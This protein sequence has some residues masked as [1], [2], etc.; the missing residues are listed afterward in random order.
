M[1]KALLSF[2]I[3]VLAASSFAQDATSNKKRPTLSVNFVL[4]DFLTASRLRASSLPSVLNSK[5]W[6]RMKEMTPGFGITYY[7]GLS[8]H[9]DFMSSLQGSFVKYPFRNGRKTS[10]EW[11]NTQLDANI[12]MKLLTDDHFC[13]PYLTAGVGVFSHGGT[14]F[15]AYM[16]VGSGLQF[17]LGN[18]ETFVFT[19]FQYRIAVTDNAAYHFNY[20]LGV[21][22]PLSAKKEM[23]KL[24]PPPPPPAP[25][26]KDTDGDGIM[27]GKDKCP[28]VKGV[29]KYDGCPVP[30]SDKDGINDDNDKCPTV[31]GL[32]KYNGCPIP[33]TDGDKV[34]DE[35]DKCLTVPGLARYNGCPIPDTDGDGVNDEADKCPTVAGPSSNNGCPLPKVSVEEKEKVQ[36][37]AKNIY[38]ATGSATL[39]SKSFKSLNAVVAIM[40]A[41]ND[42]KLVVEG[43]TDNVGKPASNKTLSQKRANSVVNYIVKK[44]IDKSRITGAGYGEEQPVADNKTAAGRAKNRRV[45]LKLGE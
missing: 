1:K 34:N 30:D 13:V 2:L 36:M 14:Y 29:A 9:F 33:D 27:D 17:N 32:A 35:E 6:A 16:P 24:L 21:G 7:E 10:G 25:V 8:D 26:E 15:G 18:Q 42:A 22:A 5:D 41:N 11:L 4:N 3:L 44:G 31:A 20:S 28:T 38:F 23:P 19:Q 12:N 45:E 39:L 37:A 40:K 43:H